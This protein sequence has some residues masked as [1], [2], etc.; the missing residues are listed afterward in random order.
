MDGEFAILAGRVSFLIERVRA[1]TSIARRRYALDM[2]ARGLLH[3]DPGS[4]S[5]TLRQQASVLK[6]D[7]STLAATDVPRLPH[8]VGVPL[9]DRARG[10]GFVRQ[11]HVTY[12]PAGLTQDGLLS[13]HAR[14]A[15][16]EAIAAAAAR[17]APSRPA[18]A[19]ALVAAQPAVLREARV[20]GSSLAAAAFVSA[21]SLFSGR[22]VRDDRVVTG[23]LAGERV[24]SVGEIRAKVDGARDRGASAILV[25]A[26]NA[27][28]ARLHAGPKLK[29]IGV[30]TVD[31]LIASALEPAPATMDAESQATHARSL[32]RTA[33]NGYRWPSVSAQLARI[34]ATLPE[35]RVD[36]RVDVLTRLGA[37]HRHSGDPVGCREWLSE[38]LAIVD[39]EE[40]QRAV[41]DAPRIDLWI[42]I[43][44]TER[45]LCRFGPAAKAAK[46]SVAVARR[47]RLRG[48]MVKALGTA[49]LVAMSRDRVESA[50]ALFGESL[51]LNIAHTPNRTAR[52]RAY[53]IEALGRGGQA[54]RMRTELEIALEEASDPARASWVR[55]SAAA[56]FLALDQPRDAVGVLNDSSIE[57]SMLDE[58]LPGLLA[59]RRLGIALIRDGAGERGF[60]M[61]AASPLVHGRALAPHLSF[62]AHV[63]VLHEARERVALGAWNADIAGR[64][65]DALGH[66]PRYGA[67]PAFLGRALADATR[68]LTSSRPPRGRAALDAL[69]RRCARL[70]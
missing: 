53:L 65:R 27:E 28:D 2:L 29:V 57:A 69:L 19:H 51:E 11:L 45:Q 56:A 44:M 39:S 61:L 13:P 70:T 20:D 3:A 17:V 9:V 48:A 41:P 63:N 50:I 40:G 52:S 12:D 15:A 21:V 67:V 18:E 6:V 37:A 60:E 34:S 55:T 64:A 32:A 33:W 59:R 35:R 46:R 4:V 7:P 47:A 30:G 31:E 10:L 24:L 68:T 8:A 36:L 25:P 5:D 58:P 1:A 66:L 14:H 49:G 16:A 38:A 43:A 23:A 42:Q 62:L 54:T 26:A 22:P